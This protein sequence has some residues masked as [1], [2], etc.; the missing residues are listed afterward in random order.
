M[1]VQQDT[2]VA[3]YGTASNRDVGGIPNRRE[4]V[5]MKFL[6]QVYLRNSCFTPSPSAISD[7]ENRS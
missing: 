2:H 6:P 3:T 5:A 1:F 4:L 7:H